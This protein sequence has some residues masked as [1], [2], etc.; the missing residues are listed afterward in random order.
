MFTRTIAAVIAVIA[1][2]LSVSAQQIDT[3]SQVGCVS[4][5][6][7]CTLPAPLISDADAAQLAKDADSI[8]LVALVH[9]ANAKVPN[10]NLGSLRS[11]ISNNEPLVNQIAFGNDKPFEVIKQ[12]YMAELAMRYQQSQ[13]DA[14]QL[15]ATG[16]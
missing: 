1:I 7:T 9:R 8:Q 2:S 6:D 10:C 4:M 11:I 12:M 13:K 16:Y 14:K 5:K 15:L 3:S